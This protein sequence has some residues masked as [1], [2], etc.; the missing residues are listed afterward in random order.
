MNTLISREQTLAPTSLVERVDNVRT[1][2]SARL[3]S[4]RRAELG[5]YFTP[6]PVARFMASLFVARTGTIRIL[7]AGAGV[8]VLSAA[9]VGE[10]CAVVERPTAIAVTVYEVDGAL[11]PY[12]QDTMDACAAACAEVGINF[13]CTVRQSD[14]IADATLMLEGELFSG[15]REAFDCAIL[16]PPYQKLNSKSASR[17]ALR[18]VGIETSNLYTAFLAL[19]TR[20]L[21][22][23]GEL[24]AITP[25]SFCNGAYFRPFREEL[26]GTMRLRRLH[27][28]GSRTAAFRDDEVLQENVILHAAKGGVRG[29]AVTISISDGAD[30]D[31]I[32]VREVPYEQVVEPGD[33]ECFIR[34]APDE[35]ARGIGDLMAGFTATL[36]DLGLRVSTGRVVDFRAKDYLRQQPGE[37][38]APLIYPTHFAGGRIAWPKETRK[39]NALQIC[40][41][42]A[43]LFVPAGTYVLVKRFSAK[44]EP[45]RIV[46]AIYDP[47][48]MP[49]E[50]VGFEN[51]LNYFHIGGSGLPNELALGLA[52]FLNSSLVDAHFRQFSGHTQVNAT[53]LRNMRYPTRDQLARL[54]ARLPA[55]LSNQR[56]LDRLVEGELLPVSG[57][58][59]AIDPL[60]ARRRIDEALAI[61]KAV[62]LPK[63][64]QNERTALSLL[65]LL[66]IN[67]ETPWSAASDPLMGITPTMDFM[68]ARYG[69][70]YKPNTRESVRKGSM[71]QLVFYG[72][73][74]ANPDKLGRPNND[75]NYAYQVE[76]S[77]LG[78]VRTYGTPEWETS[79]P[80]FKDSRSALRARLAEEREMQ[81]LRARTPRGGEIE[82][83]PGGQNELIKQIL[84]EFCPRFTPDAIL[85]A[86]GD[87]DKKRLPGADEE[88]GKLNIHLP[89]HGKMPDVIVHYEAKGWLVGD[90]GGDQPRADRPEAARGIEGD[91]RH[92]QGA[93]GLRHRIHDARDGGALP[94]EDR[95]GD[96]GLGRR[97]ADAHDP[98]QRRAI[99][100]PAP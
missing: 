85:L 8:G 73:A 48:D 72:L 81:L 76:K 32:G 82:L 28:F 18:R 71:A 56:E 42:T 13:S 9:L 98:L 20:L 37:G 65:A 77:F 40:P 50:V 4:R 97:G 45:R 7:D 14:F 12:L 52:A 39:P 66:N 34:I 22:G 2:I 57:D 15:A 47:A 21:D 49:G 83:S 68:A 26:L 92:V 75:R 91:L 93:V 94:V 11:I 67:L 38:S 46:A 74:V 53:D 84:E 16:N 78:L 19:V 17:L 23:G 90:R 80:S 87:A 55:A 5:Q 58:T 79:L 59:T 64:Q 96:R 35:L 31:A 60:R 6:A 44:E 63:G 89:E 24:V 1:A 61:I 62:E 33:P 69:K 86:V 51:H 29:G 100:R 36:A 25:R 41:E 54:A 27:V 3:D 99:S 43:E 88:M 70:V 10:L 30:D 95:L